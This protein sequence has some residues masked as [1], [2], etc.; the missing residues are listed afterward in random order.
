MTRIL[1]ALLLAV[2]APPAL[3]AH[4]PRTEDQKTLYAIGLSLARE[5]AVFRLT[6]AE[7]EYVK[8]GLADGATGKKPLVDLGAYGKKVQDLARDRT[9]RPAAAQAKPASGQDFLA[10]AARERGAVRSPSGLVYTALQEGTGPSPGEKDTVTVN[11]R[12]TLADGTE[13]DSSARRGGPAQFPLTAVIRCWAEGVQ[14][15]KVGGVARLVCPPELAYGERGST[16][17]PPG[18]VLNFEIWLLDVKKAE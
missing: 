10:A 12:G 3:A 6:P 7:L 14:R 13:F 16:N 15:M 18:A 1:V 11:Y 17:V 9:S 8:R 4:E 2:L 5:I